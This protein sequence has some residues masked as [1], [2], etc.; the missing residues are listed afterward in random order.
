MS[1]HLQRSLCWYRSDIDGDS[2]SLSYDGPMARC[3]WQLDLACSHAKG[4]PG[5][6]ITC[7]G[8]H[9]QQWASVSVAESVGVINEPVISSVSITPDPYKQHS[10]VLWYR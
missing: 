4:Q 10:P 2:T 1:R 9:R 5:D 3:P 6:D 8:N 7:T